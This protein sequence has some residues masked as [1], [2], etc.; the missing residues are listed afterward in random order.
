V[1]A[2]ALHV[3][4]G[5]PEG[6]FVKVLD[7]SMASPVASKGAATTS[8]ATGTTRAT[9]AVTLNGSA[10]APHPAKDVQPSTTAKTRI[11]FPRNL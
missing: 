8:P 5:A 1:S 7:Q 2:A 3:L 11:G 6:K 4:L 9:F 10:T